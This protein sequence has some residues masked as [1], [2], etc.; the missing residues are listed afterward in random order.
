MKIACDQLANVGIHTSDEDITDFVLL[1]LPSEFAT[2][3][4]IIRVKPNPISIQELRSLLLIAEA[5]VEE[6]NKSVSAPTSLSLSSLAAMLAQHNH[7]NSSQEVQHGISNAGT[8]S[9]G[10]FPSPYV[11]NFSVVS[12]SSHS[13]SPN[14]GLMPG[15]VNNAM[16]RNM[17]A[18]NLYNT[19][20]ASS[21]ASH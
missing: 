5:E 12:S 15:V 18:V 17:P 9:N 4:T 13:A 14:I 8:P 3:K 16:V 1:G 20:P 10:F 7:V 6:T 19:S 2:M 21:S 11:G